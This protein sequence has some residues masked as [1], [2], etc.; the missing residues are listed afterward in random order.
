[1]YLPY[2]IL[3]NGACSDQ[4]RKWLFFSICSIYLSIV[5][6]M[7]I[8]WSTNFWISVSLISFSEK[9]CRNNSPE[10]IHRY[11]RCTQTSSN[12]LPIQTLQFFRHF[13]LMNINANFQG[14]LQYL[15]LRGDAFLLIFAL[16]TSHICRQEVLCRFL[17]NIFFKQNIGGSGVEVGSSD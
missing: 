1:M 13:F 6:F 11:W 10:R 16:W 15:F 3:K 9:L 17:V 5:R 8:M 7:L 2:Y 12:Y 14:F 4:Y